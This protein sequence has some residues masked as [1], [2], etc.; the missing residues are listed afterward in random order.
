M[1]KTVT[2]NGIKRGEPA[3]SIAELYPEQGGWDEDEYLWLPGNRLVE[4]DNGFIEVLPMPTTSHQAILPFLFRM[5][6]EFA[7]PRVLGKVLMAGLPVRLWK[8]K[9]REPDLVFMLARH[10]DKIRE[11]YWL[12]ADLVMEIVSGT[13]KD[14][15]RD[16]V[17][18]RREYASARIPEYWIVDPQKREIAVLRLSQGKYAVHGK[19]GRGETATSHLLKGFEVAADS[20][21]S[22]R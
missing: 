5:L 14:R 4:F 15:R 21:F 6:F 20:V 8:G 10:S 12:G 2:R 19:F 1:S 22:Q 7:Q 17:T 11:R 16:L 3:W 13:S 9:F 18:K